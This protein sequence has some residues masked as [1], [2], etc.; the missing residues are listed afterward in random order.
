MKLQK[1]LH[2]PNAIEMFRKI[3]EAYE[4]LSDP[5]KRKTHTA[6]IFKNKQPG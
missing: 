3:Q 4:T 6:E 2:N 1:L 5:E